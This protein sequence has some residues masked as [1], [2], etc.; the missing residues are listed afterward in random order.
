MI[1]EEKKKQNTT[2]PNPKQ[3]EKKN[4]NKTKR[5]PNREPE[6]KQN[7]YSFSCLNNELHCKP[8]KQND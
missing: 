3:T 7:K 4:Q 5:T 6:V 1:Q 2:H 8:K